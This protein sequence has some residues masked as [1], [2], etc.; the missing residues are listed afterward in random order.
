MALIPVYDLIN[1]SEDHFQITSTFDDDLT[2]L[3]FFAPRRFSKGEELSMR[4]G[5]Q[6]VQESFMHMA[7]VDAQNTRVH[8][9]VCFDQDDALSKLRTML[10][11]K[12]VP[13]FEDVVTKQVCLHN[14]IHFLMKS[15][16]PYLI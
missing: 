3:L 15:I 9:G 8:V 16:I 10:M 11:K 1:H 7:F 2:K 4:Y 5:V 6:T 14:S 13:M 12:H